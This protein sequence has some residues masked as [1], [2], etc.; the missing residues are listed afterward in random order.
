MTNWKRFFPETKNTSNLFICM[1][2]TKQYQLIFENWRRYNSS[3]INETPI[4][5]YT[6]SVADPKDPTKVWDPETI[7]QTPNPDLVAPGTK[8][9]EI[10]PEESAEF[11]ATM[12]GL[13]AVSAAGEN[14]GVIL[15]KAV[16]FVMAALK[17]ALGVAAIPFK[18]ASKIVGALGKGFF[19]SAAG[20]AKAL[21][22]SGV[23]NT[24]LKGAGF[25]LTAAAVGATSVAL[26]KVYQYIKGDIPAEAI[27]H[28][29]GPGTKEFSDDI[30]RGLQSLSITSWEA[31]SL[32]LKCAFCKTNP[33][34][35]YPEVYK[36][37][38]PAG[39]KDS[40]SHKKQ[41]MALKKARKTDALQCKNILKTCNKKI[42]GGNAL[43]QAPLR[44]TVSTIAGTNIQH[45]LTGREKRL[46]EDFVKA[47]MGLGIT[48]KYT[49]AGALAVAGKESGF[50]GVAEKGS[51]SAGTLMSGRP[52]VASRIKKVFRHQNVELTQALAE[53]LSGG[54]RNAIALFNIAYGYQ[55]VKNLKYST[56]QGSAAISHNK[57]PVV[58]DGKINLKLYNPEL[59]GY[60]YRGRG[61]IQ[62]TFR[63]TY[64]KMAKIAGL[65]VKEI[66]RNPDILVNDPVIG[67]KMSAAFVKSGHNTGKR[68]MLNGAE[69]RSFEEGILLAA[70]I[71]SGPNSDVIPTRAYNNAARKAN[72]HIRLTGG[73]VA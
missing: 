58:V 52:G 47:L 4:Y 28:P 63:E 30:M 8:G 50:V 40:P 36:A 56:Y 43:S 7:T 61:P 5:S 41:Q 42:P 62:T 70:R 34:Q 2:D 38:L 29:E 73:Q 18:L 35:Q 67:L 37:K 57:V 49:L 6:G 45:N 27:E 65:D 69:P 9:E 46:G 31:A 19:K 20:I 64:R 12:A 1:T 54:G 17:A 66:L 48:N 3:T 53:Q 39:T 33:D 13:A 32:E 72:R 10:T 21:V 55:P 68:R 24:L 44:G 14:I 15:Q 71:V 25:T 22:G 23:L 26:Y 60:K 59:A 51:Y 16:G 11:M